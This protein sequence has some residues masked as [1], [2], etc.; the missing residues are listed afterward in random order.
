MVSLKNDGFTIIELMI[1]TAAFTVILMI[2]TGA[3]IGIS[4]T[5]VKG[6]VEEQTQQ[7][8][9]TIISDI[10]TDI[11]Y[12]NYDDINLSG[13]TDGSDN[14]QNPG[15]FCIGNDVYIFNLDNYINALERYTGSGSCPSSLPT[16]PSNG[17]T[18]LLNNNERLSQLNITP[19]T[20]TGLSG[21]GYKVEAQVIYGSDSILNCQATG[22]GNCSLASP[23]DRTYSCPGG[24]D[25]SSCAIS[26]LSVFVIPRVQ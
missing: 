10:T 20:V 9:R 24:N 11:Q 4:D 14:L 19:E 15:Y 6:S 25:S 16:A 21:G 12:N 26:T 22:G 1:A 8:N 3:L 5:Y 23:W 7:T 2:T 17:T 18:K 13:F